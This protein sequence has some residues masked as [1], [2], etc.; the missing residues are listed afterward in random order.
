MAKDIKQKRKLNIEVT[1]IVKKIE[2]LTKRLVQTKVI[3]E[4]ISVFKGAGLEFDGFKHYTQDMDAGEIDWKA[5]VRAKELLVQ[6]YREVREL[7]VYFMFD[8]SDSMIFGSTTKLKNEYAA[9]FI[10]ALTYTILTAGDSVGVI[11]FSDRVVNRV[12]AS[13]G[14]TQFYKIANRLMQ[15]E[16]YGGGFNLSVAS[17]FALNFIK[18]KGSVV[19]I[20]SDFYGLGK[21]IAWQK[22]LKLMS[23]KF[24][25]VCIIVRDPRDIMLPSDVKQ[26]MVED[27][28]S[29]N[30]LL[31]DSKLLKE[32]YESYTRKQ[33]KAL[34]KFFDENNIDYMVLN[35]DQDYLQA[36]FKFFNVRKSKVR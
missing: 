23:A 29:G 34:L 8:V 6:K 20:V 15:P 32:R 27:P 22:K 5:S 21:G 36:M 11:N 26:V 18:K 28:F 3:G 16:L 2:A 24:D 13:K 14:T 19:L 4:Y 9:E 12:S 25:L 1:P 30:R 31:I 17:D 7:L 35:T 10:L 33:D